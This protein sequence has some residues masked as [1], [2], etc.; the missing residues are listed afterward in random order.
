MALTKQEK[1]VFAVPALI[2]LI[3]LGIIG[4]NWLISS[5]N[6]KL[7]QLIE[8]TNYQVKADQ[9]KL[10]WLQ[11]MRG[12]EKVYLQYRLNEWIPIFQN[13]LEVKLYLSQ[14]VESVLNSVGAK[15]KDWELKPSEITKKPILS[16]FHLDALFPSYSALVKFI[17]DIENTTPPF[18]PQGVTIKK[19]GIRLDV[20]L[21]LYFSFR[22]K[23]ETT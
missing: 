13:L 10:Q 22:L 18:L 8:K 17:Q 7:Q 12:E 21:D 2:A 9:A 20:S 3:L 1:R 5:Q 19:A 4:Y 15:E 23:N 14:R 11:K 16:E 6:R